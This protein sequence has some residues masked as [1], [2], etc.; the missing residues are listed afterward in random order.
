[1]R[2]EKTFRDLVVWQKAVALARMVYTETLRL[3]PEERFGL[4]SQ[5]RR[6]AVSIASNIAEGNARESRKDYLRMLML[7]RGSLAELETQLVIAQQLKYL[8]ATDALFNALTE[9]S[10]MLQALIAALRRKPTP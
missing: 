7:A 6:A 4:T 9:V 2:S 8:E 3:P 5:M 1:M 10:R